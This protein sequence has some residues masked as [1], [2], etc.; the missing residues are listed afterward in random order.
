[1]R[2]PNFTLSLPEWVSH[3]LQE[4]RQ[5]YQTVEQRMQLA[6]R[7]A[8]LNV[9]QGSGGPFGAAVFDLRTNT[10]LAP[11]IN[12]VVATHC[13]VAHA[14]I[15]ALIFA[16]QAIGHYDLGAFTD[17]HYELVTTAEP[18]AMCLGAIPWSGIRSL[19]CGAR[20]EDVRSI[21][22]EEGE[23]PPNWETALT[24]RD[25]TVQRDVCRDEAHA[26]LRAYREGGGEIY[27]S[28]RK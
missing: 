12:L 24:R 20:D 17:Q 26:V 25:I 1:M 27:N 23:K 16:Q 15:V 8:R 9:K 22:F 7:L 28:R 3:E 6:L 2:L 18:C 11:G 14:E 4:T 19:V 5:S 21:G 13:S 10:L